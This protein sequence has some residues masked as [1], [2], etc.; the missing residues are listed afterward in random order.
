MPLTNQ[1]LSAA[2]TYTGF[3]DLQFA[4]YEHENIQGLP[5]GILIRI[6]YYQNLMT[7][8]VMRTSG[9]P[10][11]TSTKV[12]KFVGFLV[13]AAMLLHIQITCIVGRLG[14]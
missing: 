14:G 4:D 5:V 10:V 1:N 13:V 3:K 8:K 12:Q 9:G 7:G 6:D 11:A 2:K